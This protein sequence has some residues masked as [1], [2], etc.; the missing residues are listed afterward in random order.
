MIIRSNINISIVCNDDSVWILKRQLFLLNL[1]WNVDFLLIDNL[2][3]VRN[4]LCL[5]FC[6]CF[7][8]I[9]NNYWLLCWCLLILFNCFDYSGCFIN[10][11]LLIDFFW[12]KLLTLF[13]W[14]DLLDNLLLLC[15]WFL[16]FQFFSLLLSNF[17]F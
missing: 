6:L 3:L 15:F 9:S 2:L 13:L 17:L 1:L 11:F 10:W 16:I 8:L 7:C 14:N 5:N 12:N 4:C